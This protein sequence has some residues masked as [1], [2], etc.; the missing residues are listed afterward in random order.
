M[1][2]LLIACL[3]QATLAQP[4][5]SP[6]PK[7]TQ[8]QRLDIL[9]YDVDG[10]TVLPAVDIED[11]VYPFLG[12]KRSAADIERARAALQN[13][14][15]TRGYQTV[16][17][18]IPAQRGENSIIHLRVVEGR[19]GRL[20][21]VNAHYFLPSDIRKL[22][23]SLA[24]GSVPN[25]HD[26][27]NDIIALNQEPDRKVTP[28]LRAGREP[29]TLDADLEVDDRLPLHASVELNNRNSQNTSELRTI[30]TVSY[31]N[32]WQLG[33][34]L[35]LSYQVAPENPPDTQVYAASYLAR[36]PGRPYSLQFNLIK[37]N[38]NVSTIG[39]TDVVGKGDIIGFRGVYALPSRATLFQSLTA[40][41][42]Y[43]HFIENVNLAN[44]AA[45]TTPITYFPFTVGYD[46]TEQE[47]DATDHASIAANFTYAGFGSTTRQ[48]DISRSQATAQYAYLKGDASRLQALPLDASAFVEV[49]T[50]LA[51]KPLITNEQ[52]AAGGATSVRGYFEAEDL[53]D[54]GSRGTIELRSP[55]LADRVGSMVDELTV[56]AFIDGASLAIH[57]PLP[58]Q[59]STFQLA[60]AGIGTRVRVIGHFNGSLD[61]A[62]PLL[63]GVATK[64]D[65]LHALFRVWSQY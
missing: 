19:I 2:P 42:D 51:D 8:D 48:F 26:V 24:E 39:S 14:Y 13:V 57:R 35:S 3:P 29:G 50:Q 40:G 34:S 60:S 22:A 59:Q 52:F 23:P 54:Y 12:E 65:D 37:S 56:L 18:E 55:S 36:F 4:A 10:N 6:A 27:E 45:S 33:H 21:I 58:G 46:I 44:T 9:E 53:G 11:A 32:L 49:E 1:A 5:P 41:M 61:L 43:K 64:R 63:N 15:R 28:A 25:I 7:S 47:D 16:Q 38:S 30:G 31:D 17:V 20:R 62:W